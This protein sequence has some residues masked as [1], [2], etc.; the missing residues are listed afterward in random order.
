MR[1]DA[2]RAR[3][4]PDVGILG[5]LHDLARPSDAGIAR[6]LRHERLELSHEARKVLDHHQ[7]H[8]LVIDIPVVVDQHIALRHDR[9]PRDLGMRRAQRLADA[10]GGLA[11][12]LDL[13]FDGAL[14]QPVG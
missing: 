6:R 3:L 8:A 13:A 10:A 1:D 12:D 11:D 2:C 14:Q 7:P 4:L 5:R 9:A